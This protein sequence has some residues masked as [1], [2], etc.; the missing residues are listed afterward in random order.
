MASKG[1]LIKEQC[2]KYNIPFIEIQEDYES[3]MQ[4]VVV[5]QYFIL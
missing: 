3:E 5:V 1:Q 2:K 4:G